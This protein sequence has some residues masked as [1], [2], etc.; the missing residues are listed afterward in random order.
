[1]RNTKT[2]LGTI[3]ALALVLA[4]AA[5]VASDGQR[6]APAFTVENFNGGEDIVLETYRGKVVYVDFWASWCQPCLKSFPFMERL[7]QQHAADGLVIIAINMDE[8]PA[9]AVEFLDEHAVTFLIG[10]DSSGTV[11]KQFGVRA[12]PSSFVIDREGKIQRTHF[13]FKTR[14]EAAITGAITAL[15]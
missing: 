11:A 14:H 9:D 7:Y 4:T 12:L 3:A 1:M 2:Y 10:R 6:A 5:V 13:G 8:D 15:L